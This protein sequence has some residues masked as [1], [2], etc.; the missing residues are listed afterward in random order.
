MD[1]EECL[2]LE[3]GIEGEG[4]GEGDVVDGEFFVGGGS[5][6]GWCSGLLLFEGMLAEEGDRDGDGEVAVEVSFLEV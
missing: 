5:R 3:V 1:G 6:L 2:E 4:E